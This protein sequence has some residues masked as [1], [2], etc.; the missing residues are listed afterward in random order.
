MEVKKGVKVEVKKGVKVGVKKEVKMEAKVEVKKEVKNGSKKGQYH[1]GCQ[2]P[3]LSSST[4]CLNSSLQSGLN[5]PFNS[6]L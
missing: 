2:H 6:I 1:L 5:F 4:Q 3:K